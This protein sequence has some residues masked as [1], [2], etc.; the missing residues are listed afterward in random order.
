[1]ATSAERMA[2]MRARR[3]AAIEAAPDATPRDPDELLLPAVDET[4]AAL[5]LT[6][7]DGA[8][9]QLARCYARV[10]DEASDPAWAMRWIGPL[11][12]ASLESLQATPMSR[13]AAKPAPAG[14][15]W[16]QQQRAA[17]AAADA[18]RQRR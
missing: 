11:F 1:M 15:N 3:A 9:A 10:I 13:P 18:G 14:P 5:R 6:E 7:A 17:R 12:L 4:I 8:A 2:A 16:L